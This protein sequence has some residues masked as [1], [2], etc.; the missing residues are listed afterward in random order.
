MRGDTILPNGVVLPNRRRT[1]GA[2]NAAVTPTTIHATICLT[3]YTST[4]RPPSSY[5]T[6]LKEQQLA[7]GYAFRGDTT[8]SDYEEDH[9]VPLEL[10]GAPARVANLWPEPYASTGA[11]V[12]DLVENRLHDLVCS[13]ALGLRTAQQAIAANWWRAYRRYGGTAVPHVYDGAFAQT[14]SPATTTSTGL[15]PRFDTCAEAIAHG[16]GPYYE[17]KDPEYDWYVDADHDGVDCER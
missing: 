17:G 16:Y 1:P 12:K 14:S 13:G 6:A 15:D 11:R 4:I 5:T 8:L 2:V 7:S 3:G 10:G 9:L